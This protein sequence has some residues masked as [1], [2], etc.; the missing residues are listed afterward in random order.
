MKFKRT[1]LNFKLLIIK[2]EEVMVFI[3][4]ILFMYFVHS[5]NILYTP[6]KEC[7]FYFFFLWLVPKILQLIYLPSKYS[8]DSELQ[9][10]PSND[11]LYKS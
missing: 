7:G 2:F 1:N 9:T 10:Q 6:L 8:V 4:T 5:K 11:I 3:V